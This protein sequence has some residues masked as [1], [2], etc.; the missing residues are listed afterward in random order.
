MYSEWIANELFI[1][2]RQMNIAQLRN[3]KVQSIMV[4]HVVLLRA[5]LVVQSYCCRK[6]RPAIPF[7]QS[8]RVNQFVAEGAAQYCDGVLQGVGLV[9]HQ[10]GQVRPHPPL[11]L[12]LHW[13]KQVSQ[14]RAE[15]SVQSLSVSNWNA[16]AQANDSKEDGRCHHRV[17]KSLQECPLHSKRPQSPEQIQS[18]LAHLK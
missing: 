7:L 14:D 1:L 10:R 6:E 4:V 9:V 12:H 13:V 15:Q 16:A 3:V 18:A 17:I 5:E 11:S 8:L 2:H